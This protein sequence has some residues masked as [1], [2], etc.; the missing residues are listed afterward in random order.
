MVE[1]YFAKLERQW[2]QKRKTGFGSTLQELFKYQPGPKT[3][4]AKSLR[5]SD[6]TREL[7]RLAALTGDTRFQDAVFALFEHDVIDD[8]FNFLPGRAGRG[9][10]AKRD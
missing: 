9:Q 7:I 2:E 3:K 4:R 5:G 10:G 6:F 1:K 8:N